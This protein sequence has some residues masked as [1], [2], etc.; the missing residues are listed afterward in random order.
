MKKSIPITDLDKLSNNYRNNKDIRSITNAAFL[1][2]AELEGYIAD[3]R[4]RNSSCDAL[5]ISFIRFPLGKDEKG[6]ILSAGNDLSQVSLIFTAVRTIDSEQWI[7][8][9]LKDQQDNVFTLS[10]NEPDNGTAMDK[11][12]DGLCPP[13]MGCQR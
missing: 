10:I 12:V 1:K 2:I 6:R 4:A 5:Q 13:K 8:D 3:A 9:P 11:S 7:V